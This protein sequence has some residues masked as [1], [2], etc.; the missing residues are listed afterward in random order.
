M[1]KKM[2]KINKDIYSSIKELMDNA[3]NKVAREVNNILIQTYWEIG[4]IIV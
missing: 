1:N 2:N 4:R 3:R